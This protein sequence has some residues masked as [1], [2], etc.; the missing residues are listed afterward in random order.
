MATMALAAMRGIIATRHRNR[1]INLLSK[2]PAVCSSRMA[3]TAVCQPGKKTNPCGDTQH[4]YRHVF[5]FVRKFMKRIAAKSPGFISR[6]LGRVRRIFPDA[7]HNALQGVTDERANVVGGARGLP[8]GLSRNA[9]QAP[10]EVADQLLDCR[11]LFGGHGF[12]RTRCHYPHLKSLIFHDRK[13]DRKQNSEEN[14]PIRQYL[15][16]GMP[17]RHDWHMQQVTGQRVKVFC[18]GLVLETHLSYWKHIK[19]NE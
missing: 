4:Q 7:G 6:G 17:I 18:D 16:M 13:A 15:E 1:R 10:F 3:L 8:P 14:V 2:I 11:C 9:A 19:A 5:D 12:P